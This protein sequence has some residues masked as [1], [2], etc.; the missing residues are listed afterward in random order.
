MLPDILNLVSIHMDLARP[1]EHNGLY[2]S[3]FLYINSKQIL[4]PHEADC[5]S[6]YEWE[7]YEGLIQWFNS[8]KVDLLDS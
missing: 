2:G 6:A 7:H 1:R 5:S 8:I 4:R 3:I